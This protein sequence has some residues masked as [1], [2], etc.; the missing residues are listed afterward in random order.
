MITEAEALEIAYLFLREL[1]DEVG[2]ELAFKGEILKTQTGFAFFYDG[3]RMIE[4]MDP[5]FALAG[6]VPILVRHDGSVA[7]SVVD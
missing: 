6:N 1:E 5:R 3:K 2:F 7:F 4:E